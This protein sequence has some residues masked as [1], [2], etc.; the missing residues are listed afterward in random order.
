VLVD[1]E[2]LGVRVI[3]A[4]DHDIVRR[5]VRRLLESAGMT[6]VAEAGDGL[7][8]IL[9]CIQHCPDVLVLDLGM[10]T[11]NGLEVISRLRFIDHGTAIVVLSGYDD[12]SYV[13]RVVEMGVRAYVLKTSTDEDLIPAIHAATGGGS[14]FSPGLLPIVET[15]RE[16]S[17]YL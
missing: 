1:G 13:L 5:G 10:P 7:A 9:S 11:L 8:A 17:R 12:R 15:H 14:F 2:H 3:V 6:V 16:V 4:D